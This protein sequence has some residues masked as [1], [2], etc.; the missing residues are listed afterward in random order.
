[1]PT[2]NK[3]PRLSSI[4]DDDLLMIAVPKKGRIFNKVSE[5]LKG[6]GMDFTRPS[7][8]IDLGYCKVCGRCACVSV[9]W[10]V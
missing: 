4:A 7:A 10:T 6:A 1:M 9:L 5:L 2:P 3:R 8:R